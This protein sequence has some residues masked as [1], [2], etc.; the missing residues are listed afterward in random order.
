MLYIQSIR[1]HQPQQNQY[2]Y[3]KIGLK[4]SVWFSKKN[5]SSLQLLLFL[6]NAYNSTA[7]KSQ[8]D[9]I[10]FDF[11]KVFDRTSHGKHLCKLGDYGIHSSLWK[12][13]EAYLTSKSQCVTI[14]NHKLEFLL[15]LSGVPQDSFTAYNV[16]YF[17]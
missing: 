1:I 12:W 3:H 5:C 17:H 7:T 10:Y 8:T 4:G 13:F 9:V 6:D 16:C 15:V 14:D 11:K 2:I